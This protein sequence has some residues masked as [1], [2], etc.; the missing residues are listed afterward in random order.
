V[1]H[2]RSSQDIATGVSR[3]ARIMPRAPREKKAKKGQRSKHGSGN[4]RVDK[5]MGF[6]KARPKMRTADDVI[7]RIRCV[8]NRVDDTI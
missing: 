8:S 4:E 1:V 5:E 2:T 6:V 3:K 7:K